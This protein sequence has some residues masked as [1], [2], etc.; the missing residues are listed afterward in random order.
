MA[1]YYKEA[2][3]GFRASAASKRKTVQEFDTN[4]NH[5]QQIRADVIRAFCEH[6]EVPFTNQDVGELALQL[7]HPSR[8]RFA[9]PFIQQILTEQ[10]GK[11]SM[12]GCAIKLS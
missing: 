7:A 8:T 9:K 2:R 3:T 11:C 5:Q 6:A 10:D 4:P 12:C 1:S